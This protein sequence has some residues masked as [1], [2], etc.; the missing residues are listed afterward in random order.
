MK[1]K[2]IAF[3]MLITA[4]VFSGCSKLTEALDVEFDATFSENMNIVVPPAL[5]AGV[6]GTFNEVVSIDP[7]A[8]ENVAEY[9]SKIKSM[10]VNEI[11][12]QVISISK[13]V[14]LSNFDLTIANVNHNTSWTF[15]TTAISQGT[16]FTLDNNSGQW[17]TV[18]TIL[19]EQQVFTVT[20]SGTTDEDDVQ[21]TLLIT[22][23]CKVV[24]NPL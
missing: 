7:L 13:D 15:P 23:K 22:I 10:N 8:D 18:N 11:T 19:G 24:A 4:I 2:N 17:D 1:L 12:A 5:K 16:V 3:L 14:S 21:F 9:A 20:S 6:D